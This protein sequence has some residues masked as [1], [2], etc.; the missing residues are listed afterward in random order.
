MEQTEIAVAATDLLDQCEA[1]MRQDSEKARSLA[2]QAVAIGR[3]EN[4]EALLARALHDRGY[5]LTLSARYDDALVALHESLEYSIKVG[6]ERG[7][8][9][10]WGRIAAVHVL[11]GEHRK[12]LDI[13]EDLLER[14]TDP[15]WKEQRCYIYN[16]LGPCYC[17]MGQID[18]AV[19]MLHTGLVLS[20]ELDNPVVTMQL[21][22]NAG[23]FHVYLDE[24]DKA[25]SLLNEALRLSMELEDVS[26]E[27]ATVANLGT[28]ANYRQQWDQARVYNQRAYEL[29]R[30]LGSRMGELAALANMGDTAAGL[31]AIEEARRLFTEAISIAIPGDDRSTLVVIY[32][33]RGGVGLAAGELQDALMDYLEC[34]RLTREIGMRR[35]EMQTHQNLAEVYERLGD[36]VRALGHF[37]DFARLREEILNEERQ[38]A[39]VEYQAR[40]DAVHAEHQRE[41]YRVR[42]EKLEDDVRRRE[43]ELA[44]M[45]LELVHENELLGTLR[46][47]LA[48]IRTVAPPEVRG[49][50]DSI[51]RDL[52]TSNHNTVHW[53]R[54]EQ[55]LDLQQREFIT[56][57]SELYPILR[58]M[59]LKVAALLR[60]GLSS[61]DI[62]LLIHT[63]VR[64]IESHRYWIR[65]ALALPKEQNLSSF[66]ASVGTTPGA[67]S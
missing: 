22:Q 9:M 23:S 43:H 42:A 4:N 25:E 59:E 63:S 57:L 32:S 2:D 44:A 38:K 49:E 37:K 11:K 54:F 34:L 15:V 40:F 51:V 31:G 33:G 27:A 50:I 35:E 41:I 56:V 29:Y 36:T 7:A 20:K 12:A 58:P 6:S 47:R 62:A 5:A 1:L 60:L 61:K 30:R 19:D 18:R 10:V 39:T 45:A 26:I 53:K 67:R 64:N 48:R 16:A 13:Y 17:E 14:T 8:L 24:Y 3:E 66:L 46:N 52:D 55:Q 28:I 21:L 65:K